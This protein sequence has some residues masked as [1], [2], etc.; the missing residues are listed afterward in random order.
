MKTE[1][2]LKREKIFVNCYETIENIGGHGFSRTQAYI[3]TENHGINNSSIWTYIC[4]SMK[5][6]ISV[7]NEI[8]EEGYRKIL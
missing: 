6:A 7:T 2:K 1:E 3:S 4:A 8:N 5:E